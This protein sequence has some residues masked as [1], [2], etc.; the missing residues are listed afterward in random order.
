MNN[1]QYNIMSINVP[2]Y[3]PQFLFEIE[4]NLRSL[5]LYLYVQQYSK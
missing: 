4:S 1:I 3:P 5:S 2:S